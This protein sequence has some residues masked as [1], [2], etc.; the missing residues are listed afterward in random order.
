MYKLLSKF[1]S[2]KANNSIRTW[3]KDVK[4][5]F[6]KDIQMANKHM[7]RCSTL[8]AIRGMQIKTTM[9]YHYAPTRVIKIKNS[10][11]AKCWQDVKKLDDS[12]IADGDVKLFGRSGKQF[13]GFF[14]KIVTTIQPSNC[15]PGHLSREMKTCVH[16]QICTRV[17]I[18]ALFTV[19]PTGNN[20]DVHQLVNG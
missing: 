6:T 19:A 16:I 14:K 15:T 11:N 13:S 20:S 5:H 18:A 1:N 4:G 12:Y 8:L 2:K 7:K 10:D 9:R 17:F 3:E